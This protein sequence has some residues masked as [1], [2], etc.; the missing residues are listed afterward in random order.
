MWTSGRGAEERALVGECEAFLSGHYAQ[1]LDGENLGVP[2]W[3]W[4]NVL[5]HG[6]PDDIRALASGE[7]AWAISSDTSVWH[8]ALSFLAQELTDQAT[9]QGRALAGLQ[10]STLVPLELELAGR[11]GRS[12]GPTAFVGLVRS[13]MAQHPSSRRR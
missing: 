13:T 9:R 7:P 12:M 10:R 8:D 3:A 11:R 4:L 5:A 6:T 2:D 1:Y